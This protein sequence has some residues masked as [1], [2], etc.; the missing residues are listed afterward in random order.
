MKRIALPVFAAIV[1]A[2]AAAPL[3]A[4][5]VKLKDGSIADY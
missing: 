5:S 2:F 1:L 3:F 4:Y